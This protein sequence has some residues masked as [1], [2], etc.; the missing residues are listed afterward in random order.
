M[1]GAILIGSVVVGLSCSGS[2]DTAKKVETGAT[3]ALLGLMSGLWV[4]AW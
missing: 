1:G 3:L 2:E 4:A